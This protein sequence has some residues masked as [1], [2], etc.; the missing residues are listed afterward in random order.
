MSRYIEDI[1]SF[2]VWT[3]SCTCH[4]QISFESC[5]STCSKRSWC[6]TK[7]QI[8]LTVVSKPVDGGTRNENETSIVG[9][10]PTHTD[11][12]YPTEI[13]DATLHFVI[14]ILRYKLETGLV[15]QI[16]R[17]ISHKLTTTLCRWCSHSEVTLS[18]FRCISIVVN[19]SQSTKQS[20]MNVVKVLTTLLK[21]GSKIQS[22]PYA[23]YVHY[24]SW[25]SFN[26]L[27]AGDTL[28]WSRFNSWNYV[29]S[30][31][32]ILS[33]TTESLIFSSLPQRHKKVIYWKYYYLI[34]HCKFIELIFI[35]M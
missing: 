32:K 22:E 24:V 19:N 25:Y 27:N 9:A 28:Y 17:K 26:S 20:S 2:N 7:T 31:Q 1:S 23:G 8:I 11:I 21:I 10:K 6:Q 4:S 13:W 29:I 34:I 3:R 5:F 12:R 15:W 33:A 18:K 30:V 14:S 16:E 35:C